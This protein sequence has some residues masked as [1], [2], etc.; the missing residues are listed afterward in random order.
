[1]SEEEKTRRETIEEAWDESCNF[2]QLFDGESDRGA[3]VLAAALFQDRLQ[4]AIE[5]KKFHNVDNK[6]FKRLSLWGTIELGYALGLY[7]RKT[8][9][10]LR[11]VVKIRNKFAHSSDPLEF[12]HEKVAAQCRGLD[13]AVQD[14]DNL[15]ER[16]LTYLRGVA[17]S[18]QDPDNLRER[19]LTYLRGLSVRRS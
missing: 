18:V 1:M 4:K 2:Y 11:V 3:A 17:L 10:G 8:R 15:R 13:A 5:E 6:V 19:Y 9:N 7:D 14:P 12:D 16:Y